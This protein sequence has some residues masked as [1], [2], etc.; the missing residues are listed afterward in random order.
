VAKNGLPVGFIITAGTVND[1]EKAIELLEGLP[2]EALIADKGF[3]SDAIIEYAKRRNMNVVI[4]PR[5]NRKEQRDYDEEMYKLRHL[6]ENAILKLKRWR[7]VATRYAKNTPS[8]LAAVHI[9][10]MFLWINHILV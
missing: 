4:P 10:S 9:C 3:D 7:G 1:C 2:A 8:Y 6:V 5:S